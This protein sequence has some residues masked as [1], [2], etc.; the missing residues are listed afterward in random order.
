M[1]FSFFS[2]C[3]EQQ[4]YQVSNATKTVLIS[5]YSSIHLFPFSH[6]LSLFSTF[7]FFGLFSLHFPLSSLYVLFTIVY[8]PLVLFKRKNVF[9]ILGFM[10]ISSMYYH[11]ATRRGGGL[12][13]ASNQL[14]RLTSPRLGWAGK[15]C[16]RLMLAHLQSTFLDVRWFKEVSRKIF[17][18]GWSWKETDHKSAILRIKLKGP[19]RYYEYVIWHEILNYTKNLQTRTCQICNLKKNLHK[20][21]YLD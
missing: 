17:E 14:L 1:F 21:D 6:S 9:K 10:S 19:L 11:N 12:Q 20:L 5:N 3:E 8:K 4:V 2:L 7:L 15:P 13:W 18:T 16:S